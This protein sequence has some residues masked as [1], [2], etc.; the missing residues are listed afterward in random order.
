MFGMSWMSQKS[1]IMG[2]TLM[3]FSQGLNLVMLLLWFYLILMPLDILVIVPSIVLG[4]NASNCRYFIC[5]IIMD[6]RIALVLLKWFVCLGICRMT[7]FVPVL[8]HGFWWFLVESIS[9]SLL[10][11]MTICRRFCMTIMSWCAMRQCRFVVLLI[12]YI[13]SP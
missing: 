1:C 3:S 8:L 2:V 6:L 10:M 11:L 12:M 7:F 9:F 13:T 4:R 5:G